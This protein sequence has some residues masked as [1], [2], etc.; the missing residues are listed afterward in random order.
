MHCGVKWLSQV[1]SQSDTNKLIYLN[2]LLL[3]NRSV[4]VRRTNLTT[5]HESLLIARARVLHVNQVFLLKWQWSIIRVF[6]CRIAC[7]SASLLIVYQIVPLQST[8]L[9]S[10]AR[11]FCVRNSKPLFCSVFLSIHMVYISL[12]INKM[13]LNAVPTTAWITFTD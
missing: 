7:W 8:L 5:F 11:G 1:V 10:N 13:S 3:T 2:Y 6:L 12:L 9:L 4:S